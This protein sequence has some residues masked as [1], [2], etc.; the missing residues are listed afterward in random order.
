ML[1]ERCT[2][3]WWELTTAQSFGLWAM[4]HMGELAELAR[5]AQLF[6]EAEKRGNLYVLA[7]LRSF[8]APVLALAADQ[9]DRA[10]AELHLVMQ[11]WS[12]QGF[13]IPH[14]NSFY[15]QLQIEIYRGD[16][17]VAWKRATDQW[18]ALAGSLLLRIQLVRIFAYHIRACCALCAA[19]TSGDARPFLHAAEKDARRLQRENTEC[20]DALAGLIHA[21]LAASGRDLETSKKMPRTCDRGPRSPRYGLARRRGALSP[22]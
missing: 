14:F 17:A 18:P 1:R 6:S 11:Q 22:R 21:G 16:G 8:I 20:A 4:Y 12:R 9:P 3:V 15:G 7:N 5:R 10:E 13:Q 19:A 2:G